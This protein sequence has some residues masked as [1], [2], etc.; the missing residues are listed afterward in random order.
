MA[1]KKKATTSDVFN[2]KELD[3]INKMVELEAKVSAMEIYFQD[4]TSKHLELFYSTLESLAKD[5]ETILDLK[6]KVNHLYFL[7]WI[8]GGTLFL[9]VLFLL[10]F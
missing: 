7:H 2:F 3:D 8:T 1:R 6:K 4:V 9:V 10:L 5:K